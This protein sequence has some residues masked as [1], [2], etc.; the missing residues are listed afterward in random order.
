MIAT[1][2]G[3]SHLRREVL[4]SGISNA[5]IN[6]LGVWWLKKDGPVLGWEGANSFAVDIIATGLLLPFIVA[7]IVIPLQRSKLNKGMQQPIHLGTGSWVQSLADRFPAN[8]FKSACLFGAVG[9]LLLAPLTLAGIALMGVEQF[10]PRDYAIFKG[11]W[12]GLVAAILVVPMLLIGLRA[13]Q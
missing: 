2:A 7:L 10:Q 4:V 8:T 13:P 3:S 6:G 5:I 1:P 9:M 11:I 12:T